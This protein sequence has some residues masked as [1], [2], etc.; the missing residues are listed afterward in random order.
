MGTGYNVSKLRGRTFTL[1]FEG[2]E[3][4]GAE[5]ICDRNISSQLLLDIQTGA[6]TDD[7][8]ALFTLVVSGAVILRWNLED[9]D[10]AMVPISL[11]GLRA[12][13]ADLIL[14]ILRNFTTN[15]GKVPSPLVGPSH[16][17]STQGATLARMDN[18]IAENPGSQSSIDG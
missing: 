8:D 6:L 1:K 2:E 7:M 14:A 15:I 4:E 16:N 3:F 9:D 12:V 18:F 13:P 17:G 5:V 11:E 10:G